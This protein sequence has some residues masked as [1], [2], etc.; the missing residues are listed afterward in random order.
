MQLG[1]E[2]FDGVIDVISCYYCGGS[3]SI[4]PM[5]DAVIVIVMIIVLVA[6]CQAVL[7]Q[8]Q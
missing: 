5:R 3:I 4:L 8:N 2:K 6:W 7:L 1:W